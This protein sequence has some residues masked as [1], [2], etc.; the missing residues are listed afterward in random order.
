MEE[1][2]VFVGDEDGGLGRDFVLVGDF[3]LTLEGPFFFSLLL[4]FLP[5]AHIIT[6]IIVIGTMVCEAAKAFG[7]A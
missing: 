4:A 2:S 3:A 6:K 1:D 5:I 7:Y